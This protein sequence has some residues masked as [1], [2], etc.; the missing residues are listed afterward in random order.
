MVRNELGGAQL[1]PNGCLR[2]WLGVVAEGERRVRPTMLVLH[3]H[4]PHPYQTP[5]HM[6]Q[7][8]LPVCLAWQS[9]APW[10]RRGAEGREKG[11][12]PPS[13]VEL[14]LSRAKERKKKKKKPGGA[15]LNHAA[16]CSLMPS[17]E[18]SSQEPLEWC[19]WGGDGNGG[20]G[21]AGKAGGG[22]TVPPS[23]LVE[24]GSRIRAR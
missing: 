22:I 8:V 6:P 15:H 10:A 17:E 21:R 18:I 4:R 23:P 24:A 16:T 2:C 5:F 19:A 20:K 1:H 13:G 9:L 12:H 14:P 3:G 7:N 11:W